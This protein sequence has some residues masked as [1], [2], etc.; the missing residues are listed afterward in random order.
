MKYVALLRGINVGGK[1][2]VEMAVLRALFEAAGFTQVVTYLNTGNVVF[3]AAVKPD[4]EALQK[5]I[6][7]AFGLNVPVLLLDANAICRIAE[8][9]PESWRNDDSQKS[10]VCYLF[11]EVDDATIVMKV[12]CNADVETG[13]YVPGAF[14]WNIERKNY[15]RGSLP[16]VIGTKLY[17]SMTVRNVN[18]ARKL[19]ELVQAAT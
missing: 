10:D 12:G 9:I 2:K 11:P 17:S 14:L 19:A 3:E 4:V 18:T 13:L 16:K 7:G 6:A 8:S 1:N 5:R 15:S